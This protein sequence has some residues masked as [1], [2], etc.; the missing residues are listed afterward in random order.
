MHN[1]FGKPDTLWQWWLASLCWVVVV[2]PS[3][4][5]FSDALLT[6]LDKIGR[7]QQQESWAI[8]GVFGSW[9]VAQVLIC[10]AAWRRPATYPATGRA[11]WPALLVFLWRAG[12]AAFQVIWLGYTSIIVGYALSGPAHPTAHPI[13]NY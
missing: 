4:I 10:R 6:A 12:L 13:I 5:L 7:Q 11:N 2:V 1:L 3:W 9:G 8:Y